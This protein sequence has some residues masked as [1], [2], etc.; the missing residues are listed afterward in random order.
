M[1]AEL[2]EVLEGTVG[3]RCDREGTLRLNQ[4]ARDYIQP[5][6]HLQDYTLS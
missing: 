6:I 2:V 1:D 5:Y 3:Y 4:A